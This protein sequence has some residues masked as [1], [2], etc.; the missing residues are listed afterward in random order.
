M[1]LDFL[2]SEK[3]KDITGNCAFF[4]LSESAHH[5]LM[6]VAEPKTQFRTIRKFADYYADTTIV[7]GEIGALLQE[8]DTLV[9]TGKIMSGEF[10]G[11]IDFL[12]SAGRDKLNIYIFA[13]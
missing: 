4:S 5:A 11:L 3:K 13:D 2:A 1:P 10:Q 12:G 8:I 9:K 6:A 7:L